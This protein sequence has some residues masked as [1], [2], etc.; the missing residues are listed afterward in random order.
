LEQVSSASALLQECLDTGFLRL[1]SHYIVTAQGQRHQD[2]SRCHCSQ[3]TDERP[4][5]IAPLP[6]VGHDDVR[7]KGPGQVEGF[8]NPA[9][10]ADDI[11]IRFDFQA[12]SQTPAHLIL[13][14]DKQD[15]HH[16]QSPFRTIAAMILIL[17]TLVL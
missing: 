12:H 8:F 4:L 13:S 9:C 17:R 15:S 14:V 6:N 7:A 3:A 11:Y 16:L 10:L 1:R 2:S 5:F